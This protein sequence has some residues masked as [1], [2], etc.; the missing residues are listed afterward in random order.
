MELSGQIDP[1]AALTPEKESQAFTGHG[2]GGGGGG[3][4]AGQMVN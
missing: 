2:G 1:Q 3:A 4:R